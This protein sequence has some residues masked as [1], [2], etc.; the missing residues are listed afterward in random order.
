MKI[1]T[2]EISKI[3]NGTGS[4]AETGLV[5]DAK[6]YLRNSHPTKSNAENEKQI[7]RYEE[8]ALKKFATINNLW[9]TDLGTRFE[10]G[11]EQDVFFINN[12]NYLLKANTGIFYD[13]WTDY[14]NNLILHNLFFP[15][16][17]YEL[18]GFNNSNNKFKCVVKQ[19]IVVADDSV[20]INDLKKFLKFFLK[21]KYNS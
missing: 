5:A 19:P 8:E 6:S 13:T 18:I 15:A 4:F 1:N 3:I 21:L 10:G 16:T 12:N 2:N 20:D 7:K 14:L 9:I 11:S 17:K